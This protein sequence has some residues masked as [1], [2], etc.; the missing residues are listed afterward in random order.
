MLNNKSQCPIC[1]AQVSLPIN[2]EV[3]EIVNCFDCNSRLVVERKTD[4]VIVLQQAPTI[5]E[6]WGE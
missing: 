2:T 3:S 4:K 1:D 5:E 6:D